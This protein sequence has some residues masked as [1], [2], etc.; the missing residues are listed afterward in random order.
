MTSPGDLVLL[1][2]A[3]ARRYLVTL[4]VAADLENLRFARLQHG[5]G[6]TGG[7][8]EVVV[9]HADVD[10]VEDHRPPGFDF[11]HGGLDVKLTEFDVDLKCWT[12][13]GRGSRTF[14][15]GAGAVAVG[16]KGDS[17]DDQSEHRDCGGDDRPPVASWGGRSRACARWG[18]R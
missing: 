5:G 8:G 17:G 4:D 18:C 11:D 3:K 1:V 15:A 7:Q 10:D 6:F 13:I 2:D 9:H 16:D 14:D 12:L